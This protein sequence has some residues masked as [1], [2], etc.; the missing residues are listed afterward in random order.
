MFSRIFPF[1]TLLSGFALLFSCSGTSGSGHLSTL[2]GLIAASDSTAK[3]LASIDSA[4]V[5]RLLASS[6][7]VK[8]AFAQNVHDTLDLDFARQLDGFLAA[9]KS[10]S[11]LNN[12]RTR[13]ESANKAA[14]ERLLLLRKDI[15]EG[16]G[17][18][19]DYDAYVRRE[20]QEMQQIRDHS[21]L[22]KQTF[23]TAKAAITQ[24]QP[25]IERF[26]SRFVQ[27][28]TAP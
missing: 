28:V 14:R 21:V 2:S 18:R 16:A 8:T 24:F 9:N 17:E 15:T 22:L 6:D 20:Q 13:C 5:V 4:E 25:E 7:E 23:E 26:I 12:E 11:S 10:L 19:S 27:P 1:F 3:D